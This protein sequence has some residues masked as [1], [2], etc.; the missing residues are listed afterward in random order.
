MVKYRY[1]NGDI[2]S[3]GIKLLP[4]TSIHRQGVQSTCGGTRGGEAG[5][6]GQP[7][8]RFVRGEFAVVDP[9]LVLYTK[10]GGKDS[11]KRVVVDPT[12]TCPKE[13]L[14]PVYT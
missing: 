14:S 8:G 6:L 5:T 10:F 7:T 9:A 11:I 12:Y 13:P 2:H 1:D 4:N 3:T